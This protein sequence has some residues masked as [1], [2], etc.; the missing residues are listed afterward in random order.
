MRYFTLWKLYFRTAGKL[1]DS[2]LAAVPDSKRNRFNYSKPDQISSAVGKGEGS[3]KLLASGRAAWLAN[4]PDRSFGRNDIA[5]LRRNE[6]LLLFT[7]I[8]NK[9]STVRTVCNWSQATM[10]LRLSHSGGFHSLWPRNKRAPLK[11]TRGYILAIITNKR[12]I[13]ILNLIDFSSWF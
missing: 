2:P 6:T 9:E 1:G 13:W 3:R 10:Y 7:T 4:S 5:V 8:L 11:R 12:I